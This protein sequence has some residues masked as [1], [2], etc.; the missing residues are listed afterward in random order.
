M[1]TLWIKSCRYVKSVWLKIKSYG[2]NYKQFFAL[3][4]V[5]LLQF[6]IKID[7]DSLLFLLRN[8]S[9]FSY[10]VLFLITFFIIKQAKMVLEN[11]KNLYGRHPITMI[12]LGIL[13]GGGLAWCLYLYN[14]QSDVVTINT[15]PSASGLFE[16][17]TYKTVWSFFLQNLLFSLGFFILLWGWKKKKTRP[18]D[19]KSLIERHHW[20]VFG[21]LLL[22]FVGVLF[23]K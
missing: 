7:F 20:L 1:Q 17:W 2:F 12:L 3:K 9:K 8:F 11:L 22:V 15:P 13:V 10:M 21:C 14:G 5:Q 4:G 19:V 23:L 18:I 16:G 6:F